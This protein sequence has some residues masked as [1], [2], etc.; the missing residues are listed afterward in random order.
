MGILREVKIQE[1]MPNFLL[2][3]VL[4]REGQSSS[5]GKTYRLAPNLAEVNARIACP[6]MTM[7]DCQAVLDS[8]QGSTLLSAIDIKAAFNNIPQPKALECF[9]GIITQDGIYTYQVIAWGFNAAP[10][11]Y[12][13]V[14]NQLMSTPHPMVPVPFNGV[15]L[16]DILVGGE[17][18]ND[19]WN[20]TLAVLRCIAL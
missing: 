7:E 5:A 16:D 4:M 3:V 17:R 18:V 11:Y 1:E 14:L 2:S 20:H 8:M 12:Q 19:T 6:A 10:C 9:T 15:Y 13:H